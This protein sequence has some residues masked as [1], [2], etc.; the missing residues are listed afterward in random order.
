MS[1]L[2]IC[3]NVDCGKPM[4]LGVDV[5]PYYH[6]GKPSPIQRKLLSDDEK[7]ALEQRYQEAKL[8]AKSNGI[9]D[10]FEQVEEYIAKNSHAVMNMDP[11]VLALLLQRETSGINTYYLQV[12]G[13]VH[14]VAGVGDEEKR[15]AVDG[16]LFGSRKKHIRFA[17]LSLNHQ[18][19]KSYGKC[20]ITL[21]DSVMKNKAT[22]LWENSYDFV[23][24]HNITFSDSKVPNGYQAVWEDRHKLAMA[25]VGESSP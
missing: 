19:L 5:C 2:E 25:K 10:T 4:P 13:Q 7:Q 8:Q 11:R 3:Q 24:R 9:S 14:Q 18:G 22:L 21:A 17:A 6:D 20:S 1:D 12:E 23:E 15:Q 16:L